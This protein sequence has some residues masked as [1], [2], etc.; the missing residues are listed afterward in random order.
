MPN[1]LDYEEGCGALVPIFDMV[2]HS[3]DPNC[4]WNIDDGVEIYADEPIQKGS[5]LFIQYGPQFND[6][7]VQY[8]GF[9]LPRM[10]NVSYQHATKNSFFLKKH[11]Q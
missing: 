1:W 5:E 9:S 7:L 2:N 6:R 3:H 10:N 11:C 8:Y 4:D